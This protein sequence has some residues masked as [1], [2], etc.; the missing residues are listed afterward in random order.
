MSREGVRT[1]MSWVLIAGP[2]GHTYEQENVIELTK[3]KKRIKI[4]LCW[5]GGRMHRSDSRAARRGQED[6]FRSVH[7]GGTH[8]YRGNSAPSSHR[9]EQQWHIPT[10]VCNL[11]FAYFRV[12]PP[13]QWFSRFF[14]HFHTSR[15][16]LIIL[17]HFFVKICFYRNF[18]L[19]Y[20]LRPYLL[21]SV[22][23]EG[24]SFTANSGTKATVL[25]N[26][27]MYCSALF[28]SNYL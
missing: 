8:W 16:F 7:G 19:R 22:L 2:G 17:L 12:L 3:I 21:Q 14:P 6:D 5:E 25:P 1:W 26:V 10:N 11:Q 28:L 13:V 24:R 9:S 4:V 20:P 27:T 23:P 18:S 15:T